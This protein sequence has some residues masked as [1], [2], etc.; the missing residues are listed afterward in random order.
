MTQRVDRGDERAADPRHDDAEV[1]GQEVSVERRPGGRPLEDARHGAVLLAHVSHFVAM[2]QVPCPGVER[3]S[4]GEV[5][6]EAQRLEAAGLAIDV[7]GDVTCCYARQDKHWVT[8]PDGQRWENYVVLA[9]A[10]P[11]L[12]G[13]TEVELTQLDCA[14]DSQCCVGFQ[15]A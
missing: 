5:Q 10:H 14:E 2:T 11:D 8:G 1:A 7:E 6:A 13:R 12:E 3:T 4:I 15:S 9:D